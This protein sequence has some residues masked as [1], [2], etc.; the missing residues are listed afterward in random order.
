MILQV[1]GNWSYPVDSIS[2]PL[3][4]Y[5]IHIKV[6]ALRRLSCSSNRKYL[7]LLLWKEMKFTLL[8]TYKISATFLTLKAQYGW[9]P[10]FS[11]NFSL[12]R[13]KAWINFHMG[14][15]ILPQNK[16]CFLKSLQFSPSCCFSI[17][18]YQEGSNIMKQTR[19]L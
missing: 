1:I 6:K 2:H 15:C 10:H 7:L 16:K 11:Y 17:Y 19:V 5:W 14:T 3:K 12:S 4:Y 8:Y 9:W 18:N 13:F